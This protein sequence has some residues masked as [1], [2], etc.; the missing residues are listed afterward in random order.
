MNQM[1]TVKLGPKR[2]H[3]VLPEL[4]E[5]VKDGPCISGDMCANISNPNKPEW[6]FCT[7]EHEVGDDYST[8]E[9]LIR[10]IK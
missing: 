5:I 6:M 4:W 7:E 9:V 8:F 3:L 10:R 1:N 2:K